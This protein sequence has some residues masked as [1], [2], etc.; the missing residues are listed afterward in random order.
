MKFVQCK[1]CSKQ[2]TYIYNGKWHKFPDQFIIHNIKISK[3]VPNSQVRSMSSRSH[4]RCCA[5]LKK[6]KKRNSNSTTDSVGRK[7]RLYAMYR[8]EM[9]VRG[10]TCGRSVRERKGAASCWSASTCGP[11]LHAETIPRSRSRAQWGPKVGRSTVTARC[12]VEAYAN[13]L[14]FVQMAFLFVVKNGACE[15]RFP[16]RPTFCLTRQR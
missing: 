2:H 14:D 1:I 10:R 11:W 8:N 13:R 12:T 3:R 9:A 16:W 4:D 6:K 15:P 7:C 5:R